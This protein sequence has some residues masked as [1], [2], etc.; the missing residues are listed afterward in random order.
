MGSADTRFSAPHIF[1]DPDETKRCL[2][3]FQYQRINVFFIVEPQSLVNHEFYSELQ[4]FITPRLKSL[5]KLIGESIQQIS[6]LRKTVHYYHDDDDGGDA[7]ASNRIGLQHC[8]RHYAS[9]IHDHLLQLQRR[10]PLPV[11]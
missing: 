7:C 1:L 2:I 9:P 5:M 3:V 11:L 6:K 4:T 8:I 10:V